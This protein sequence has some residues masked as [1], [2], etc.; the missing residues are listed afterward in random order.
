[1][2]LYRSGGITP[3]AEIAN[4]SSLLFD[5]MCPEAMNG[6]TARSEAVFAC[7]SMD[8]AAGWMRYR[9]N[10]GGDADVW[11]LEVPDDAPVF[12]HSVMLFEQAESL[13]H[14]PWADSFVAEFEAERVAAEYWQTGVHISEGDNCPPNLEFL[15]PYQTALEADW[16]RV[17]SAE[18]QAVHVNVDYSQYESR[19]WDAALVNS[20][21]LTFA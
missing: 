20:E 7:A 17:L 21:A 3:L 18:V 11:R 8:D 2:F 12:G 9:L 10:N 1:M 6:F 16:V 13:L 19:A 14:H 4:S 5:S 15:V